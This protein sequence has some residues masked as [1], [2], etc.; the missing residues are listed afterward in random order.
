MNEIDEQWQLLEVRRTH[1]YVGT[2]RYQDRWEDVGQFRIK[3]KFGGITDEEDM[4]EP[5]TSYIR[6]V[7]KADATDELI[8]QA[9]HDY[10]TQAGCHHEW[11]C[12]GCRSYYAWDV[13][14]L[15]DESEW[16]VIQNS[17]RNY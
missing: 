1:K 16:L 4:C 9:L 10:F 15:E 3:H 8:K 2:Y 14:K 11:D 7:V 6:V 12:C 17:S 13:M 5:Y